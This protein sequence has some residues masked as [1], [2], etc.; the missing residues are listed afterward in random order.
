[1]A[2][3]HWIGRIVR[4]AGHLAATAFFKVVILFGASLDLVLAL[5]TRAYERFDGG[6]SDLAAESRRRRAAKVRVAAPAE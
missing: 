3:F 1:M 2:L 6:F 4:F 5:V